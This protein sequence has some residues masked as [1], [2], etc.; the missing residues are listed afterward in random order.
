MQGK[1]MLFN[2]FYK[3]S[4]IGGDGGEQLY[5]LEKLDV[6][7]SQL[8]LEFIENLDSGLSCCSWPWM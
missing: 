8:G 5:K 7:M 2:N 6:K 1:L 3:N 4:N